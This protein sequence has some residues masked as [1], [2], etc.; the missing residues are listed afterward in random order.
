MDPTFADQLAD[1]WSRLQD[2]LENTV[3]SDFSF[4]DPYVPAE[5]PIMYAQYQQL[6]ANAPDQR[7][8]YTAQYSSPLRRANLEREIRDILESIPGFDI[9][10]DPYYSH[11]RD[12]DNQPPTSTSDRTTTFPILRTRMR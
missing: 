11:Y 1:E 6:M 12:M 10:S 9:R 7:E 2:F 5:F 4:R 8:V 3:G